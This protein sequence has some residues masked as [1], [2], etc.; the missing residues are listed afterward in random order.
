[1][2]YLHN[3][4]GLLLR[5]FFAGILLSALQTMA[6]TGKVIKVLP[7]F[8]DKAGRNSLAPSLYERDAYQAFLRS[9]P[10][11]R[12][13]MR[14]DVQWKKK[15]PI[16]EELKVRVELR[17]MAKGDLPEQRVLEQSVQAGG[18]FS[19]WTGLKLT[20]EDYLA[21]QEVTAWRVTLWE[22]EHLLSE[23]TSFLW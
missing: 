17:G 9:H 12:S 10:E 2:I 1:M 23:Q 7:H 19:N 6:A 16:W 4:R 5:L 3:M 18:W 8:L 14:F 11:E 22:G 20:G 13:G 21:F 15:G